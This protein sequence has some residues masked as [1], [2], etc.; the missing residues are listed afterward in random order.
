MACHRF[1]RLCLRFEKTEYLFVLYDGK[2][3]FVLFQE[4][5]EVA[6]KPMFST[7]TVDMY[8]QGEYAHDPSPVA[9]AGLYFGNCSGT[10]DA[11][12]LNLVDGHLYQLYVV[13]KSDK[14]VELVKKFRSNSPK[15]LKFS[16]DPVTGYNVPDVLIVTDLPETKPNMVEKLMLRGRIPVEIIKPFEIEEMAY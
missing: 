9:F 14:V 8:A 12:Q 5:F 1:K 16:W 4:G 6:S 15:K 13:Y 11:G 2:L 3:V 7:Y 10:L